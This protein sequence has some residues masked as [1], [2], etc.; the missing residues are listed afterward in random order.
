M[1]CQEPELWDRSHPARCPCLPPAPGHW[2]PPPQALTEGDPGPAPVVA[3][4]SPPACVSEPRA[5]A[6][7]GPEGILVCPGLSQTPRCLSQ[8][9][10]G[11]PSSRAATR[12]EGFAQVSAMR[13]P[14]TLPRAASVLS[15]SFRGLADGSWEPGVGLVHLTGRWGTLSLLQLLT[16]QGTR[17]SESLLAS[18][19]SLNGPPSAP[20]SGVCD[21]PA[22]GCLWGPVCVLEVWVLS[23]ASCLLALDP[24][25]ACLPVGLPELQ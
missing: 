23:C 10:P 6:A 4:H 9:L 19:A 18:V 7:A 2:D 20:V 12:V 25:P 13:C 15:A 22:A 17:G 8:T 16:P 1:V 24:E 5:G 11:A 14:G 21:P 3:R